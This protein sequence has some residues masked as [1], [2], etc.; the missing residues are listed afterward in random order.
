MT[1]LR[2]I[3]WCNCQSTIHLLVVLH[4]VQSTT[5][6]SVQNSWQCCNIY[7]FVCKLSYY[8]QGGVHALDRKRNFETECEYCPTLDACLDRVGC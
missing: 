5:C 6:N 3:G 1:F 2:F 8:R 4:A 7:H